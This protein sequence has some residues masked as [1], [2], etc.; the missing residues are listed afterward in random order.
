[1][2]LMIDSRQ[3]AP[4]APA[5]TSAVQGQCVK[6]SGWRARS[7]QLCQLVSFLPEATGD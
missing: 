7:V 2:L 3:L 1:M 6:A 4:F 5:R